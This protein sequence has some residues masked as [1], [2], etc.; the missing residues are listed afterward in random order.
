M[1][2]DA[3]AIYTSSKVMRLLGIEAVQFGN[4]VTHSLEIQFGNEAAQFGNI[5]WE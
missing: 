3:N 5:V 2:T 1:R 4:E